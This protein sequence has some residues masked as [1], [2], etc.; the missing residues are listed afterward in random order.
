MDPEVGVGVDVVET[1]RVRD[2]GWCLYDRVTGGGR[3]VSRGEDSYKVPGLGT[4]GR[5]TRVR[6]GPRRSVHL[7]GYVVP[8]SP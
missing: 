4:Q 7:C 3:E 6:H 5:G 1:S 8:D 2:L